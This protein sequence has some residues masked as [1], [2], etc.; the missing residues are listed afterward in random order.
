VIKQEKFSSPSDL[1]ALALVAPTLD[2]T[3]IRMFDA[4]TTGVNHDLVPILFEAP[5]WE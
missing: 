3:I 1:S 4:K 2:E 5:P